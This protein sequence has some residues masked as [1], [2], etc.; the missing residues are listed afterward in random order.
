M[1][2]PLDNYYDFIKNLTDVD[3][4]IYRWT[5]H[6][7]KKIENLHPLDNYLEQIPLS[8]LSEMP[9]I[10]CHDQ[11]PLDF[12]LYDDDLVLKNYYHYQRERGNSDLPNNH[13]ADFS[14]RANH[15]R[16]ATLDSV[17]EPILLHSEKHSDQVKI[18]QEHGFVPAY[19]CAHFFLARD[20]YR[21]AEHDRALGP[22]H[23][24]IQ[25]DFLI[26][27]RSWTDHREYR[28]KLSEYLIENDLY[29]Q[30]LVSFSPINQTLDYRQHK[31]TNPL[32]QIQRHDLHLFFPLNQTSAD[33]SATYAVNDYKVTGIEV[34][35][36]T[37]F[38]DT[39]W[40]F[41]EKIFRPIACGRPFILASTPRSLE[42]LKSLGFE[43]FAPLID[44]TYDIIEDPNDRLKAIV[45]EMK[46]IS[47][48]SRRDKQRLWHNIYN[49]AEINRR[50]F[51]SAELWKDLVTEAKT[52]LDLAVKQCLT[53][54]ARHYL[55]SIVQ[56][57]PGDIYLKQ[58]LAAS[59]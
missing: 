45:G 40:H 4:L 41:T 23:D 57:N 15:L 44:E 6:G 10:I 5:P 16:L 48:L 9:G 49:I 39:K 1:S 35:L 27:N 18:Y 20:W 21:Y 54:D 25:K 12:Y 58:F 26:Y 51:F 38:D 11:E 31:F 47:G 3:V 2:I 29:Q 53:T 24:M 7:S 50:R 14:L 42:Y 36:E 43:T 59:K 56:Y 30:C 52:N 28:L 34:V 32:L 8:V 13:E 46:R 22:N 37:I 19:I 33:S 55:E 17:R